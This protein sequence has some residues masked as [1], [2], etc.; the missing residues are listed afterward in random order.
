MPGERTG[1]GRDS[2][3]ETWQAV[4]KRGESLLIHQEWLRQEA[5]YNIPVLWRFQGP[6]DDDTVVL[7]LHSVIQATPALRNRYRQYGE[8][9][10]VAPGPV[11]ADVVGKLDI[12][13]LPDDTRDT[14]LDLITAHFARQGLD[15]E[16]RGPLRAQ[17]I[18]YSPSCVLVQIVFHHICMDEEA[19][20]VLEERILRALSP[21]SDGEPLPDT[22]PAGDSEPVRPVGHEVAPSDAAYWADRASSLPTGPKFVSRGVGRATGAGAVYRV[23]LDSIPPDVIAAAAAAAGLTPQALLFGALAMLVHRETRL[24][25]FTIGTPVSVRT[26]AEA[27]KIGHFV[28]TVPVPCAVTGGAPPPR[29][30]ATSGRRSSTRSPTRRCHSRVCSPT[31]QPRT[32]PNSSPCFSASTGRGQAPRQ[33][34]T[35]CT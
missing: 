25:S 35:V 29:Y 23:A 16:R 24:E 12:S 32:D 1:T 22:P 6:V 9:F 5:L 15:L 10:Y 7:A 21:G 19:F 28:N 17:V 30:S 14:E 33:P 3:P 11:A 13:Q 2:A 4:D 26:P 31:G 8:R 34:R 27:G 18:R 20:E